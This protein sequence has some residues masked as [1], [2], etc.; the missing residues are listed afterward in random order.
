MLPLRAILLALL[1]PLL[2]PVAAS[3][4]AAATRDDADHFEAYFPA[5][6]GINTLHADVLRPK[7]IAPDKRTPVI[8]TVS[9]YTNHS[10]EPLENGFTNEGPSDRFYDFLDLSR[11]LERGY[12]YVMVDLPGFGGSS[13]C[14]DWGG[15]REQDAVEAAV[16][17]AA[18]QRWSTGKVGMLGKSY[19]AWTGLM[20]VAQRPPG[21]EAVVAMEP[22]YAGYNYLYNRGVRFTNSVLTPALFQAIDATPGSV[23]DSP[24]Y[25]VNGAPQAWCYGLNESLQ[26]IDSPHDPF[27]MERN[28]LPPS[29]RSRVPLFL[30]QGFLETNTKQDAA[31]RFFNDW[32]PRPTAPGSA[33]STTSAA[34]RRPPT[35]IGRRPAVPP[36]RSSDQVLDF[37]AQHLKG[38]GKVRPGVQVQDNYGR[39][40]HEAV[41]PPA[42]STTRWSRLNRGTYADDGANQATGGPDDTGQGVW[43]VSQP[44]RHRAWLAGE[45]QLRVRVETTAP[46]TN[47]VGLVYDIAPSGKA[48]LVSRGANLFRGTGEQFTSFRLYGQDWV[49]APRAPDRRPP[50]WADSSWWV[51]A[52]TMDT[53]RVESAGIGL[54]FLGR[55]RARFLQ[56]R[57]TPR[58]E[59]HR[60]Q[61][62]PVSKATIRRSDRRFNLPPR[63]R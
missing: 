18:S 12:T 32:G 19:D 25:H 3:P 8:L 34:G 54:P 7:G 62:A 31:Y 6:D 41:W 15:N 56:G 14:N 53:V 42:D 48:R 46:R 44:L 2:V 11:I 13:G 58:L 55:D 52:P 63:L 29:R 60:R 20:G 47:L 4:A 37:F 22:V 17:W 23:N 39:Y 9:P 49:L 38:R 28:L 35:A 50:L 61:T 16:K 59:E 45:P 27:W 51:H 36:R 30:T 21:L 26:Q 5:G 40:R 1:L 10:G 24:E 57:S 33:S 43:S